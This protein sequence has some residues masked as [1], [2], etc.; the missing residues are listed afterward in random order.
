MAGT[1]GAAADR[2]LARGIPFSKYDMN[3]ALRDQPGAA[4][5]GYLKK[6]PKLT[7]Q[8]QSSTDFFR[9]VDVKCEP[10]EITPGKRLVLEGKL[11]WT[12]VVELNRKVMLNAL[13]VIGYQSDNAFPWKMITIIFFAVLVIVH[14]YANP[15][16][17]VQ[18]RP[19]LCGPRS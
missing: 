8:S 14:Q 1:G 15:Y 3:D 13:Y 11:F 19:G 4:W 5:V 2:W 17:P 10:G 12:P 16:R 18:P 6:S 9:N 7:S